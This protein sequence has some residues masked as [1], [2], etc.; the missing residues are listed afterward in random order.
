MVKQNIV[1]GVFR[2]TESGLSFGLSLLI[3]G[4]LVFPTT[5][6]GILLVFRKTQSFLDQLGSQPE[7]TLLIEERGG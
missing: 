5:H 3:H 1:E 2:H 4:V 7:C 6:N